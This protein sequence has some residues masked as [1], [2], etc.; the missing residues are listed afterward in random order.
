MRPLVKV[1]GGMKL[2][3][4]QVERIDTHEAG[5]VERRTENVEARC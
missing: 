1:E 2:I 5:E 3:C 4:L